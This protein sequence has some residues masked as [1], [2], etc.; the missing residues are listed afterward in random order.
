M[1]KKTANA[2]GRAKSMRTNAFFSII[3][4]RRRMHPLLPNACSEP[5]FHLRNYCN[6]TWGSAIKIAWSSWVVQRQNENRESA[7]AKDAQS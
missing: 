5:S 1:K 2:A 6:E 3:G 7:S 4:K